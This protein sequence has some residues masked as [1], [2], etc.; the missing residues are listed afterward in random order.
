MTHTY[1]L[2]I[3]EIP[4]RGDPKTWTLHDADHLA[5]CIEYAEKS[6]YRDWQTQEG[7]LSYVETEN[8]DIELSD[9]GAFTID[10]Y[11]AWLAQDLRGLEVTRAK[12]E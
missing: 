9:N 2:Q 11:L 5:R 7:M 4:H 1:P 8:G 6:G 10:A 12:G 3:T